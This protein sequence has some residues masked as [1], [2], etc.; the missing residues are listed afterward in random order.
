MFYANY[1]D[2]KVNTQKSDMY[3]TGI[4]ERS[5]SKPIVRDYLISDKLSKMH[6]GGK[7]SL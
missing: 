5:H 2:I 6:T 3:L 4:K 7:I 1:Q